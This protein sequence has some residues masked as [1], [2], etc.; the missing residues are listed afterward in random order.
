MFHYLSPKCGVTY[1]WLEFWAVF[2][3][4]M[5][6]VSDKKKTGFCNIGTHICDIS[7]IATC[8]TELSLGFT[9]IWVRCVYVLD[10]FLHFPVQDKRTC[11]K[12]YEK[13][14]K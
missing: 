8:D 13:F 5:L 4:P 14:E 11:F 3:F 2:E 9:A 6:E 10:N 12:F 7:L 1:T